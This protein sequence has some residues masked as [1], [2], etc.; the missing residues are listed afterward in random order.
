M[1]WLTKKSGD[2]AYISELWFHVQTHLWSLKLDLT[3]LS[4]DGTQPKQERILDIDSVT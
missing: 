2:I 4:K 1:Y 3:S